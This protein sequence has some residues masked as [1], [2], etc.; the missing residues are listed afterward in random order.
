[1]ST[2]DETL[3]STESLEFGSSRELS[4]DD[5]QQIL[6]VNSPNIHKESSPTLPSLSPITD[7]EYSTEFREFFNERLKERSPDPPSSCD[8]CKD[9]WPENSPDTTYSD[10]D[11]SSKDD[12]AIMSEPPSDDELPERS[13]QEQLLYDDY[14]GILENE[15][16]NILMLHPGF[17]TENLH[18]QRAMK[19][20]LECFSAVTDSRMVIRTPEVPVEIQNPARTGEVIKIVAAADTGSEIQCFGP[21]IRDQYKDRIKRTKSGQSINTGN[22][23]VVCNEYLPVKLRTRKGRWFQTKFWF[24]KTLPKTFDWLLG[25]D[26]LDVL[27]WEL[28]NRYETYEHVPSNIDDINEELDDLSC[29]L[30][31]LFETEEEKKKRREQEKLDVKQIKVAHSGLRDFVHHQVDEYQELIAR[32]EWDSGRMLHTEFPID[33]ISEDHPLKNGF[34]SREYP[35]KPEAKVEVRRQIKGMLEH[36]VIEPCFK[37]KH[38]S[39]P[40]TV[41]KKTGDWRVVFDYRK[42][43]LI[44]RKLQYPIPDMEELLEK[45]SKKSVITSLDMKGGYWHIPIR[46]EDKSKTAFIFDGKVY[47]WNVLPFGP[48][49]AP[50]FF[51][52]IMNGIFGH[53]DFVTVYLD[54]V[55]IL[56]ESVEQH[57]KHL[58]IVFDLLSEYNIKLRI[59]K[60]L[61]GVDRTEYLG[62]IVDKTGVDTKAEYIEKIMDVPEPRTR[63]QLQRFIG[64]CIYLLRFVPHMEQTLSVLSQLTHHSNP[65]RFAMND[66][67]RAAFNQMKE[68][69]RKTDYMAHPDPE[70]EYHLFTD[71]SQIGVGGMLTQEDENGNFRP[72]AYC[73]KVFN[74]TQQKWHVSEQELFASIHCI[75]KWGRLL[76]GRKFILHTDHKN[77]KMLFDKAG[78]FKSGKLFRWAVRLQDY[79]FE[80]QYIKGTD[81]TVADWLSRESVALLQPQYSKV[82]EFYDAVPEHNRSRQKLSNGEGVDILTLYRNFVVMTVINEGRITRNADPY[83]ELRLGSLLNLPIQRPRDI[84]L[85]KMPSP[86]VSVSPDYDEDRVIHMGYS[87]SPHKTPPEPS[88][89]PLESLNARPKRKCAAEG[90]RTRRRLLKE[91]G[92]YDSDVEEPVDATIRVT[93]LP[94][95]P[96]IT[97]TLG[98]FA[99]N[100]TPTEKEKTQKHRINKRGEFEV[101]S[102]TLS[103]QR[104]K[105]RESDRE[106]FKEEN[107][108]IFRQKPWK[109]SWNRDILNPQFD[110]PIVDD[111]APAI[112][113]PNTHHSRLYLRAKQA[114]DTLCSVVIEFLETGNRAHVTE[115]PEL[116]QRFIKSG[117]FQIDRHN[118]LCYSQTFADLERSEDSDGPP[119]RTLSRKLLYVAPA[120]YKKSLM[121]MTHSCVHHGR[122][123]MVHSIQRRWNYWWPAMRKEINLWCQCCNTCQHIKD[124]GYKSYRRMGKLKLF[125]AT[126]PFQQISVDIVGPLPTSTSSNRY[127]VSIIDKFSRYCMLV[128]VMDVTALSVVKA[129]D[130]WITTFGPPKS[131]LS[132]NGPQ[133]ISSIYTHYMKA[134][135]DIKKRYTSTYHP[136]CNGQIE[137][138]HRWI[139]ER[140][141]LISYDCGLNFADGTD[142]WSDYLGVIQYSWNT[143]PSEALTFSPQHIVI[144]RDDYRF[145]YT[146][147]PT[148][149]VEYANYLR[150]RRQILWKKAL[151]RQEKYDNLRKLRYD[152]KKENN[153]PLEIHQKVLW[154]INSSFVGNRRKF[155]QRWVGPYEVVKVFNDGNNY[156]IRIINLSQE[157]EEKWMN[158]RKIPKRVANMRDEDDPR[159]PVTEFVVPRN[160]LKPYYCSFEDR[161]KQI[162]R[163]NNSRAAVVGESPAAL[164]MNSL[165]TSDRFSTHPTDSDYQSERPL[166]FSIEEQIRFHVAN[167]R[168]VSVNDDRIFVDHEDD[169]PIIDIRQY[170]HHHKDQE[171][172]FLSML[173]LRYIHRQST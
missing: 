94:I 35:M 79:H 56:S 171:Q 172:R 24:L 76:R 3:S 137:R 27:G 41:P 170:N 54:D 28:T 61:W 2:D 100:A 124:G 129:I 96:E 63:K 122:A 140:L 95:K 52:Q 5:Y 115:L 146:K 158:K 157:E 155:G 59:D 7:S 37:T 107:E 133:F 31:P 84:T 21:K 36:S 11:L 173:S 42:L 131:I 4:M 1:M 111:Y 17:N 161:L 123:K 118:I 119:K 88:P 67:Q 82:K 64:L 138:L 98:S 71:A 103:V 89:P 77:L 34:L 150:N 151:L 51:Q 126:E 127:I 49:N 114:T 26:V 20:Y 38:I 91:S 10:F 69:I 70:K 85:D 112:T 46:K 43:N 81:N 144:G 62:F 14:E 57:K 154:N 90:E 92:E 78:D 45:F 164:A 16:R 9:S 68:Q 18:Y 153:Q 116:W 147:I 50:M 87:P 117:R 73:S 39:A 120:T 106:R 12:D 86:S 113:N 130:R 75:E 152:K 48:T 60:C 136:E 13:W 162:E 125:S 168:R 132:D 80:C 55:S 22:G 149:K 165:R 6:F 19:K 159:G 53:L 74:K 142:D 66:K 30:Y 145:D 15:A 58:K 121:K 104:H 8:E 135:G 110:D 167:L 101:R 99:G 156:R 83:E 109:H 108:R 25:V 97:Y 143:T 102:K 139:K 169:P 32:H 166:Q 40:F 128:P 141:R 160:Q 93:R 105:E 163:S 134:H 47:Q 65:K 23:R 44:T 33:F 29:Q 148:D 72:I